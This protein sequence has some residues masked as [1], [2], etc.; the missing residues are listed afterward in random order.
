MTLA[1]VALTARGAAVAGRLLGP[2][3]QPHLYLPAGVAEGQ[4]EPR[5]RFESVIELTGEIFPLYRGLVYVMAAGIVVRSIA[6]CVRSKHADP[7]VVVVDDAARFAI[8]LLSGHEGGA[9]NLAVRVS[10]ALGAEPVITTASETVKRVIVGI[11]SRRGVAREMV[12]AALD[13]ALQM[14][15]K[16]ANAV[17]WAATIDRKQDERGIREACQDYG[18]P[19]RIISSRAVRGF[20]GNFNRSPVVKKHLGVEGVCEPCALLAGKDA[21][22]ILEKTAMDGVT[23]AVAMEGPEN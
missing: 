12:K 22:L 7:G 9:N 11:G 14:A 17:R 23:I 18:I 10:N 6:P 20:G 3:G 4:L 15:G 8:S 1:V 16:D 19:L 13:R 5:R 21:H 2:L